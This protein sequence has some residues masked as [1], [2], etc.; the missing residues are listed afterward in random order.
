MGWECG[1]ETKQT[2]IDV[3]EP[4]GTH[5]DNYQDGCLLRHRTV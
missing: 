5:G 4:R 2:N 3:S 1:W